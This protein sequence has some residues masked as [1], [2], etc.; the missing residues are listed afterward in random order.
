LSAA[1]AELQ[2]DADRAAKNKKRA[3][4]RKAYKVNEVASLL[5]LGRTTIY[6]LIDLGQL[7]RIKIGATTLIPA[8]DV[9]ALLQRGAA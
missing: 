3:M 1:P 9:D 5:G 2:Q 6:R 8:E 7:S 4:N